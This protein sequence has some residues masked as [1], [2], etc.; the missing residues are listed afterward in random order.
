MVTPLVAYRN[1]PMAPVI[2]SHNALNKLELKYTETT[3]DS[4]LQ[5]HVSIYVLM[6]SSFHVSF[7]K[8]YI[9]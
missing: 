5:Y 8:I 9:F 3:A 1:L 4:R 7:I 6:Y 2:T